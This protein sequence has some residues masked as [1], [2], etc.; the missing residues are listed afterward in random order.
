LPRVSGLKTAFYIPALARRFYQVRHRRIGWSQAQAMGKFA[1]VF[2][3]PA[4]KSVD[5]AIR[6]PSI[7][8]CH[9]CHCI[10]MTKIIFIMKLF[11]DFLLV[12]I[13]RF[14]TLPL[15]N[16]HFPARGRKR[17]LETDRR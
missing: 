3:A 1:G 7:F 13:F 11:F 2:N 16:R 12:K 15:P 5:S 9:H 8:I 10:F 14:A 17:P 4:G 6:P